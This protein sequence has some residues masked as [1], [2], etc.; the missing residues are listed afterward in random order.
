[1]TELSDIRSLAVIGLG[2]SGVAA[3]L[4]A[5]RRLGVPVTAADDGDASG[6]DDLEEARAA[7]VELSLGPDARLP[8]VADVVVKSPGVP[9]SNH[10]VRE[11]L[12]RGLPIWSEVEFAFRFLDNPVIGITG[13]NGKTTT[14]ELTGAMVRAA[15]L[16][17]A[18]A[19][20]VGL[21]LARLPGEIPTD[22]IVVA[23]LSSF[24]LEHIERFRADVGVLLNL[25]EDHIDRHG[26]FAG[27]AAAKLRLFENQDA[28]CVAVLFADDP[29][30]RAVAVPGAGRRAW[31]GLRQETASAASAAPDC[32]PAPVLTSAGSPAPP[33]LLA[34]VDGDL[35]WLDASLA[36]AAAGGAVS[37]RHES[38][39]GAVSPA[40]FPG[41]A[42]AGPA[43]GRIPLCTIAE[44]A[45][46]G[47][48][49]VA[50]SLAA[51]AAAAAVGVPAAAIAATLRTFPGVK[52][53]LQVVDEIDGVLYVNDSKATN[54]D[55]ALKALTAYHGPVFMILGGSLKG[56]SFDTLAAGTE[57]RVKQALLIGQAAPLLEE[58]FARRAAEAPKTA[59]PYLVL[60]DLAAA[61]RAAAGAAGHGDV[62]L[63]SPACASFDQYRNFERRGEDFIELVAQLKRGGTGGS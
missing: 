29:E 42:A 26:T 10:L 1:M 23:E 28:G 55:A 16:P 48:H 43:G 62:V 46:K 27:Y 37:P 2:R 8:A 5:R 18:V 34:G 11:A 13:T 53:R 30:V 12:R 40:M 45:L 61:L 60:D 44:L 59:T 20:N 3:A 54:V 19:G 38:T 33:P 50:N 63:L 24:Q 25:T 49:N 22:A 14:T 41:D 17:C 47:D 32:A 36:G 31:F 21:A 6:L 15:G 9:T 56:A 58:A 57:G 4:L 51:A 35:L 39:S 7:G 52:H